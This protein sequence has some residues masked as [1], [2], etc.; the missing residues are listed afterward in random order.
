[1]FVEREGRARL[2]PV[3]IGQMNGIEAQVLEGLAAGDMVV[4]HP[5]DR[6]GDGARVEAR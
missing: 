5:S 4:V 2:Q 6:V 3:A 1:V